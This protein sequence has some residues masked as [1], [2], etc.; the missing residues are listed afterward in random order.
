MFAGKL[1]LLITFGFSILLGA[2]IDRSELELPRS[3]SALKVATGA[4]RID[5]VVDDDAWA[6]AYFASNFIQRDPLEGEAPTETTEFAI[7][8]DNEYVYVAINAYD[9][10][11]GSIRSIL[12][13]RD[14]DTPSDWVHVSFDSYGDNRTAFEFWLN[15]QGVKRD[16]RRYDDESEDTNWDAI[17]EGETSVHN[18]G[19]TAEFRIPLRE[20]RFSDQDNQAWGLQVYRHISRKNEDDYWTYWSKEQDGHVRH[21]GQLINL[22]NIPKQRRIYFSPYLTGKYATS[23]DYITEVHPDNYNALPNAGA[24]IKVG[25]ANNLTLDMTFNPDFGQVEADP[26]VL[27]LND[28]EVFFEEKRPFFVEGSNIFAFPV[29]FGQRNSLFYTRRIGRE[30]QYYPDTDGYEDR[31]SSSTILAA[32]KLSGKT[33]SGTSVGIMNTVTAEEYTTIRFA[34]LPTEKE[35]IEPLTNYF[36]GR[37]QQDFREGR[38]TIGGIVTAVNRQLNDDNLSF[39]RRDAYTGGIDF[40]HLFKDDTYRF[41]GTFAMTDVQGSHAAMIR[42]QRSAAH[43]FQRPDVKGQEVDSTATRLS[44]YSYK[45][46]LRQVRSPHWRWAIRTRFYSPGFEANDMGFHQYVG[47]YTNGGFIQYR[48][49]DPGKV[50]RRWNVNLNTFYNNTI[51]SLDESNGG[52][53]NINSNITFMN[54]WTINPGIF[55]NIR[56]LHLNAL[57]GGPA[58]T[59]DPVLGGW[60]FVTSDPRKK[61]SLNLF[62]NRMHAREA[63]ITY[64]NFDPGITWRPTEYFTFTATG[65]FQKAHDTWMPWIGY[66]P[67]EDLQTG[68]ER[69]IV[70]TLDQTT[71]SAELRFDLTLTPDLTIQFYGSPYFDAGIFSEDKLV[72]EPRSADFDTRFRTFTDADSDYDGNPLTYDLDGDEIT[73]FEMPEDRDFN[74]KQFNSNFVVRWEYQTGSALYFVWSNNLSHYLSNGDFSF[75]RDFNR[76]FRSDGENVFMIK[77]SY[78]LNI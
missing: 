72:M 21:Y 11:P 24:D 69:Y 46:E 52:G 25:L 50:I 14:E 13:R 2:K 3:I 48:E 57:F 49:D 76:L 30:P 65:H 54:Y 59:I 62:T 29:D 75:G 34:D 9:S 44:G 74:F 1:V 39:L 60:I 32:T 47:Q 17:W 12:S 40:S 63:N 15:P 51:V 7:L 26:A 67:V 78:L 73:N 10:D 22:V 61:L 37:V 66:G 20:L 41:Q 42:T 70:A 77:A 45:F 19:W 58:L 64:A 55:Y 71:I 33:A 18:K 28:F 31:P 5:G 4:I 35:T 56:A 6:D 36:V 27:N 23:Q 16:L 38:T 68:E 43:Y 53:G 8:Y